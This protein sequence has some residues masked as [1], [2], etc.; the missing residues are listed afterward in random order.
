[1]ELFGE[2]EGVAVKEGIGDAAKMLHPEKAQELIRKKTEEA[3]KRLK[4]FKPFKFTPPFII[5]VTYTNEG[6]A[7][8]AS[9][10]PGAVRKSP[11][12]VSFTSN[13]FWEILKFFSLAEF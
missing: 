8:K 3:L 6:Y 7:Q 9:W 13:D 12:S 10:I 11:R 2:V 5:E 1:M 4:D